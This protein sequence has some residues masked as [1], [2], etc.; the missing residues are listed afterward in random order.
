MDAN[1]RFL[2]EIHKKTKSPKNIWVFCK[3]LK[4][5]YMIIFPS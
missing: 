1:T 4:T 2:N 3:A 5:L